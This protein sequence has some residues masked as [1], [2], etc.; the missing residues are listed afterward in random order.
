[1]IAGKSLMD[2]NAPSR[3]PTPRN[4]ATTTRRR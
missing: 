4:R 2:R 3:S 1:M